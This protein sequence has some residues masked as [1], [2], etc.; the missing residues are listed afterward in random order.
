[1]FAKVFEQIFDSSI[2]EDYSIRHVFMDLLVLANA[3]GEVDMTITAVA[4]R[5][6]VPVAIVRAAIEAL[7]APDT[8]SRTSDHQGRRLLRLSENRAWGWRIVN[9]ETYR[10]MQSAEARRD[11]FREQKRIERAR[12][13][14]SPPLSTVVHTCP[15]GSTDAE[16]EGEANNRVPLHLPPATGSRGRLPESREAKMLARL[17]HREETKPWSRQEIEAFLALQPFDAVEL[18]LV[19]RYTEYERRRGDDGAHR[20]DLLKLLLTFQTEVDRAKEWATK[21]PRLARAAAPAA[22]SAEPPGFRAWMATAYPE[23][24]PSMPWDKI[25]PDVKDEY[26]KKMRADPKQITF[27]ERAEDTAP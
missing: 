9:Y 11:Y 7:E 21:N 26:A 8:E 22:G 12:A 20:R 17:F 1:M 4:R 6:N 13:K 16:G 14:E 10:A 3:K 15:Q 18:P 19:C 25:P 24:S 23:A 5:T 27:K 2:A